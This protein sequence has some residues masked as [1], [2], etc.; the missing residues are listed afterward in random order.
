MICK[1][2]GSEFDD[3][4]SFCPKCGTENKT[5]TQEET[6]P[7]QESITDTEVID[8]PHEERTKVVNTECVNQQEF[9]VPSKEDLVKN[10][11]KG[12]MNNGKNY[13]A[14]VKVQASFAKPKIKEICVRIKG[15][16]QK[17]KAVSIIVAVVLVALVALL[18]FVNQPKVTSISVLY[19]G[20]RT[21]GTVLDNDNDG[22]IVVARYENNKE[23]R[24]RGWT[25]TNPQTLSADQVS[26]IL[27]EYKGKKE[28]LCVK[29][30]TSAVEEIS[31]KYVGKTDKGT[32]VT[33]SNWEVWANYYNSNT[34][35]VADKCTMVPEQVTLET[36]GTYTFS[37]SYIDPVSKKEFSKDIEI[38]CSDKTITKLEAKYSGATDEGTEI[39]QQ[40]ED[41]TVTATY[42]D[43][44]TEV[45]TGWT[46]DKPVKLKADETSKMTV[47]YGGK[48]CELKVECST[49]SPARYKSQCKSISYDSLARN[50]E[51]Y[52]GQKVKFTGRVVQVMESSLVKVYRINVT[53]NGYGY[54]DDTVYVTY[55]GS[56]G[57]RILEDDVVTFYGEFDGL[58]T[59]ETVLG[60]S[61]T[62]P[63]V[64]AKYID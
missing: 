39:N 14:K 33:K 63:K 16:I 46:L 59:Y 10:K 25:V 31:P 26:S 15:F 48:S 1:K 18:I 61:L 4:F 20:S 49:I 36:D 27:I 19:T 34:E 17:H 29:C 43:G 23:K 56:S 22:I 8:S 3:D 12:C 37:F 54:Y 2:C 30:D 57:G 24:A 50:P 45:V 32:V 64:S 5:Q 21:A 53:W 7:E 6:A 13:L 9:L 38:K 55:F 28:F 35:N 51:K 41:I 62:I 40:S 47:K 52:E 11:L 42:K 58:H 44:T 60:S